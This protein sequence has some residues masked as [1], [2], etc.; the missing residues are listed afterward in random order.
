MPVLRLI[1]LLLAIAPALHAQTWT[2]PVRHYVCF[3][4]N[5]VMQIDGEA[6]EPSW[7]RAMW[8]NDFLDIEGAN[9]PV[10]LH[11]TRVKMCWDAQFLYVYAE[12][13]EPHLFATLQ[14]HDTIIYH[15]NDFE[16]FLDPDGDTHQY[17]EIEVNALNTVMDLFMPKPYRNGGQAMLHWDVQ[18]LRTA[19]H[20]NGTLNNPTDKDR[21]WTVEM[22]IPFRSLAFFNT[23]AVP[24]DGTTWRINFS[25]VQWQLDVTNGGY[26]K[27]PRTAEYNWVWS[28][29]GVIDMHRPERWA[30][31]QFSTKSNAAFREPVTAKAQ[32]ALWEIYYKQQAYRK[33][34][35]RYTTEISITGFSP[36]IE[37]TSSQFTATIRDAGFISVIDQ[38]GK[39]I[40]RNE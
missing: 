17:F 38:E 14:Q 39:I 24:E 28:P 10:P 36:V 37:A 13:E 35:K 2:A 34:N 31:L 29:Q 26:V 25:R 15:D 16:V 4:A 40:S 19:V 11:R 5:E 30:Y 23:L 20:L 27:R 3:Q 18:D 8:T 1:F 32:Q 6:N 22:A 12:L 9:K 7:Q 21:S 33:V